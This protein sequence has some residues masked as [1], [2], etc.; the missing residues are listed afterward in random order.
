MS[1]NINWKLIIKSS[2]AVIAFLVVWNLPSYIFCIQDLTCVEQRVIAI[3]VFAA[4]MW[5]METI[6]PWATSILIAVLLLFTCSGSCMKFFAVSHV[7]GM[8][9]GHL[10]SY[11]GIMAS[12][13]DPVIMLFLGGFTIAVIA[14]KI[15]LDMKLAK[16]ILKPF[17]DKPKNVML[18]F[19]LGTGII[20]MFVSDSATAALMLGFLLPILK[21]IKGDEI[22]KKG[23]I[24]AIPIGANIGGMATPI[25]T[26]PNAI[27]VRYLN[28]PEV[29]GMNVSFGDWTVCMLPLSL[30]MLFF[31]WFLLKKLFPFQQGH[32]PLDLEKNMALKK[33]EPM[34][35]WKIILIYITVGMTILLWLTDRLTGMNANVVAMLPIAVFCVTGILTSDDLAQYNWSVLWMVA[36]GIALGHA[37]DESGLAKH[38]ISNIPFSH[39]HPALLLF[40]P[41]LICFG[42]ST[43]ISN[44][45]SAALLVPVLSV[46]AASS[47]ETLMP[48]GG[49]AVLLF[50]LAMSA[51]L[52]MI[53]PVSTP[54]NALAYSTNMLEHKDIVRVGCII[55][56]VGMIVGY[57]VLITLGKFNLL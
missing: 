43:F 28:D 14:A 7:K 57:G 12:F 16:V 20:S 51:S 38:I 36:G 2:I 32:V 34:S 17:G 47:G 25:G 37:L 1:R 29:L 33:S 42:L 56:S 5:L 30:A 13:A 31:G 23:L 10:L 49:A 15:G 3:F 55:G 53:L 35:K 45:A 50:G 24:L 22:G 19:I 4:L 21:S 40:I 44:T 46:V 41:G 26:P 27:V 48:L 52:P 39:W 11:K 18:G 9:L 8:D 6:T 54:S